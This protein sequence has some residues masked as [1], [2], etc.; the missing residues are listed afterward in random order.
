MTSVALAMP[1]RN[2]AHVVS[3]RIGCHWAIGLQNGQLPAGA[4]RQQHGF[5]HRQPDARFG[6]YAADPAAAR[7]QVAPGTGAFRQRIVVS[8]ELAD[9]GTQRAVGARNTALLHPA[10]LVRR[11]GLAGELAPDPVELLA[12]HHAAPAAQDTQRRGDTAQAATDHQ[13]IRLQL[14]HGFFRSFRLDADLLLV[15]PRVSP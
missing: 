15:S 4:P 6:A 8:V 3:V 11:H 14:L 7:I 2:G 13:Y 12:H 1:Q 10:V 9:A 5:E